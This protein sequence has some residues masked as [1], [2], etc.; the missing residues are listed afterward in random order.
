MRFQTTIRRVPVSQI[1]IKALILTTKIVLKWQRR[2]EPFV[3]KIQSVIYLV[4]L[5]S[6]IPKATVAEGHHF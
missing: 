6:E 3:T 4:T 5:E 2:L 1:R